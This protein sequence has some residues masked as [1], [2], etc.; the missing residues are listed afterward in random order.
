[1]IP[2][3]I[4]YCWF[5]GA[6]KS[7]LIKK[8][9]ASWKKVMPDY[10][11]KEWNE[12]NFNLEDACPFVREA[13][14]ARK[15]AFIADYVRLYAMYTEGGVYMDTDVKVMKTYDEFLS[16]S[17]F[18]C[19]ESHPDIFV[20][21]SVNEDGTRNNDYDYV[22][23]IG[24]CSAVM[25]AEKECKY[26]K[27]CIDFYDSIHFDPSRKDDFVIVN[28]IARVL[29]EY[30]YKYVLDREQLLEGN[31]KILLPYTFAGMT[32]LT[33]DSYALHLY[34]GSWVDGNDTLKHR[35]R[36]QFPTIYGFLQD[37]LYKVK[38]KK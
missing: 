13:F 18:T 35:I 37:V 5:G 10:E 30:G 36:N 38:G 14:A 25:G 16:Y 11:L 17:F 28:L 12:S 31:M 7:P 29:E 32:T 19:Q 1:M 8:C 9:I 22:L 21:G 20:E 2:K 34:N 3:V 26:L 24:L 33:K 4:H 6:E 27:S 15:W 23:G